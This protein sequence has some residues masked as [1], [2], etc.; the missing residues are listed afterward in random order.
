MTVPLARTIRTVLT[1]R[2]GLR[3]MRTWDFL[4]GWKE[5]RAEKIPWQL[6]HPQLQHHAEP[7]AHDL[8]PRHFGALSN[9]TAHYDQKQTN[10]C[11]QKIACWSKLMHS[12]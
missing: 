9:L 10:Q 5:S 12:A 4:S 6:L 8:N 11:P 7:T 2:V 3:G 1:V